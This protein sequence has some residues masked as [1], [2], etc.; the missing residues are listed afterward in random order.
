[1]I[2]GQSM[3][4]ACALMMAG[5]ELPDHVKAVV[6]DCAYTDVYS[7]FKKQLKEWFHL[8]AFPLIDAANLV[9]QMRGGYNIKDASALEQVKKTRLPVLFIHGSEDAFIP[10]DMTRELYQ[11]AGGEKELLIVEGAGHAQSQD[12]DPEAY[13]G[14][15]FSFLNSYLSE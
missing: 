9:L 4:A 7:I 8:P 3:G 11:A 5:D 15:V 6:S 13:Y 10:V 2:H 12:K 14:T 1:M